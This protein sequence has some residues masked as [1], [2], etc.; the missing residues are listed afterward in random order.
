MGNG[1]NK[2]GEN[3]IGTRVCEWWDI[4]LNEWLTYLKYV[5]QAISQKK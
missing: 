2:P 1:L 3:F 4:C 5:C